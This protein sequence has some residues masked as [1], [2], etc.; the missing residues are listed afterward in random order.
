MHFFYFSHVKRIN[1]D[2]G[3]AQVP[4]KN[5]KKPVGL[6]IRL[7]YNDRRF[8]PLYLKGELNI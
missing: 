1:Q 7:M 4:S 6:Y 2:A 3:N 8:K 5:L